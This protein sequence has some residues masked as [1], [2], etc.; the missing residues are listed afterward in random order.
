MLSDREEKQLISFMKDCYK[1]DPL[2]TTSAMI[3]YI[4]RV[5]DKRI[6][7]AKKLSPDQIISIMRANGYVCA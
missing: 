2:I 3:S 1:M 4:K 5:D 7:K 6:T